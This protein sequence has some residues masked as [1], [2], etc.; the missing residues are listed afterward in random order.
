LRKLFILIIISF[1][2]SSCGRFSHIKNIDSQGKNI[3]CFGDSITFGKG[4]SEGSDY[5]AILSKKLNMPVINAGVN[6]DTTRD[7][8]KRIKKAVLDK[9]PVLVIVELGANDYLK[10]IKSEE[11]LANLEKI[12]KE[13]QSH[14]A[15][16]AIT[17]IHTGFI[18]RNIAVGIRKLAKKYR[19]LFIPDILEGILGKEELCSDLIHPNDKGYQIIANRI[20]GKINPLLERNI[21]Y[22]KK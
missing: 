6:G 11:T 22:R 16:V 5:P 7:A 17:E 13:I 18:M 20:Y 19:A 21:K 2:L 10:G 12:I 9:E 15:M 3:I 1:L 8:L 14:G 4:S